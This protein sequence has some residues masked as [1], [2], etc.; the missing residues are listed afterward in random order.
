M[1]KKQQHFRACARSWKNE[2]TRYFLLLLSCQ[3]TAGRWRRGR[4]SPQTALLRLISGL[5]RT[6]DRDWKLRKGKWPPRIASKPSNFI[7]AYKDIGR[8][9]KRALRSAQE[10]RRASMKKRKPRWN[11]KATKKAVEERGKRGKNAEKPRRC[12][13][14][15][16]E[17]PPP[18]K[19][20]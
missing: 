7:D 15:R 17:W 10:A 14:A 18:P 1:L 3:F 8:R 2:H 19:N 9:S 12:W 16:T 5:F 13:K 6:S 11:R 20:D 4:R